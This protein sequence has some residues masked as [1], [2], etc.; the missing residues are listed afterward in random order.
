[1]SSRVI[2]LTPNLCGPDGI[3]RLARLVTD[4]FDQATVLA[5]HEPESVTRLGQAAVRGAGGQSWRFVAAALRLAASAD[6]RTRVIVTHLQLAPVALAFAAGGA[7]V[8]TILCGVEAWRPVSWLQGVALDRAARLM[9]ISHFTRDR[10]QKANPRFA[11]HAVEVCHLGVEPVASADHAPAGPPSALIVG[12]MAVDER[13]KGHDPLLEVWRDVTA[14]VPGAS[15]RIVGDGDD[16]IRLE[17][18]AAS[19]ALGDRVTFL[20]RLDDDALL[21]EYERCTAFV[22]PSRDEGF[23]FVFVE[24][25]RAARACVG[26]RGA[27]AEIIADGETGLLVEPGDHAQLLDRVVR[28]LRDRP[29]TAAMGARGRARF[30]QQFTDELFRV[31]FKA[32]LPVAS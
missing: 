10:F 4:T 3:S 22:M 11:G 15:L 28:V 13:Y 8:T 29:A 27:A 19:L 21:S 6:R 26:S 5:L 32:L 1:M 12:R 7:S 30:L 24:A 14:A 2:V 17:R 31:R 16:R 25:M 20:G 9:A 23:G 18:K